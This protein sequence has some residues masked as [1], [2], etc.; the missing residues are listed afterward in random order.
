LICQNCS[1]NKAIVLVREIV[2]GNEKLA[3]YCEGCA[4]DKGFTEVLSQEKFSI[5]NFINQLV[6]IPDSDV[7]TCVC[8]QTLES[9]KESGQLG[10]SHCYRTFEPVLVE[11][12]QNLFGA[13]THSGKI[14]TALRQN[15]NALRQIEDLQK[16]LAIAVQTE[17]YEEAAR[18]RDS[19]QKFKHQTE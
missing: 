9:F 3:F 17:N 14:P 2:G 18:L 6:K 12:A 5:A 11:L 1:K 15:L 16:K 4:M 8:G 19:I 10:C 13:H 7:E